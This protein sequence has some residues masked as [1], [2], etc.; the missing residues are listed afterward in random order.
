[1][2]LLHLIL[3]SHLN[4]R[5]CTQTQGAALTAQVADSHVTYQS[6]IASFACILSPANFNI[7]VF[8]LA[9]MIRDQGRKYAVYTIHVSR[10][11]EKGTVEIWDVFRRYS[12]FHDLHMNLSEKFPDLKDL[13]LPAKKIMKNTTKSFLDK[14]GKALTLYIK[15]KLI[16]LKPQQQTPSFNHCVY[17]AV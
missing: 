5:P 7:F 9:A 17:Y 6:E 10:T 8:I 12:E 4:S 13:P 14:R 11:D 16:I 3:Y 15:V 2:V 1:M